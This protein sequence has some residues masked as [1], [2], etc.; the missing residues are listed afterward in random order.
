MNIP[1]LVI[2]GTHSGVGKTTVVCAVLAALQAR[3]LRVQP[4]KA[5]PD[6]I[7]PSHHTAAAGRA[8]RNLD[9]YFLTATRLRECFARSAAD[10]DLAVI[11]GVMGLYDGR[12]ISD[13]EGSTAEVAGWLGAPVV[14]VIDAAAMA[15]SAAALVLGYQQ[16]D[17][18]VRLAGVIVNRVGSARHAVMVKTAVE[19]ATGVPVLGCVPR[20]AEISL[21]ER[22]LG[23][24]LAGE[25]A[26]LPLAALAA[27]AEEHIDVDGLLTLAG[28]VAPVASDPL[29]LFPVTRRPTIARIAVAQDAAFAFYYQDN[30]DLL[31]AHGAE[32]VPFSPL[33]DAALPAE[34]G[35]VYI[36]GGY[37]ELHARAL[38]ANTAMLN[39]LRSMAARGVPIYAECGGLMYLA[40]GIVTAEGERFAMAGLIPGWSTMQRTRFRLGYVEVEPLRDALFLRPGMRLRG[41]EF[42][43]SDHPA[44]DAACAAYA[45]HEPTERLEGFV[46]GSVLASYVHLHF[47][48]DP[49][50]APAFVRLAAR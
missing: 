7:D 39:S 50:L 27:L 40:E 31:T 5:G 12:G 11:E 35:A 41:H 20:T 25:Q 49:G 28:N 36:G 16:F 29:E 46:N 13:G 43:Y 21:P 18:S 45:V 14:L 37:P 48:V 23:L 15:R 32:L 1:R 3:G 19:R 34:T 8:S 22:H 33:A 2:A 38:A 6:Y 9:S 17:P 10:A 42:H 4:Y 47:G 30:L 24:V 44:P 26:P